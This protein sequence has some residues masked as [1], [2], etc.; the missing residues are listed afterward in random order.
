M[1]KIIGKFSEINGEEYENFDQI[2]QEKGLIGSLSADVGN[3]Q[4]YYDNNGNTYVVA[5]GAEKYYGRNNR[6]IVKT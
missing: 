6:H 3:I 2:R 1:F 5:H 4:L